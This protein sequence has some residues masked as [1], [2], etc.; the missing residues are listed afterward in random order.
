MA[1]ES[2]TDERELQRLFSVRKTCLQMLNDRKYIIEDQISYEVFKSRFDAPNNVDQDDLTAQINHEV[3]IRE[4]LTLLASRRDNTED[5]IFVF[6]NGE[7]K[8]KSESIKIYRQKMV[9]NGGVARAILVYKG[10]LTPMAKKAIDY[11][12]EGDG[13]IE[14]F[15]ETELIINI[16]EHK[17]V[18]QHILL[19]DEEVDALL[20]RY[21]AKP[22]QLPRIS[23]DD[24]IARYYG[25]EVDQV[26]K[27][28]R[29]SETAGRYV[30]YRR[31]IQAKR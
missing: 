22:S 15:K 23:S 11:A 6:F 16:T 31:V 30:T 5:Q 18:P 20:A 17:W 2:K 9:A 1:D 28:V 10:I 4:K 7:E 21:K 25:L 19:T 24:P 3:P 13:S 8:I 29:R 12:K 27:I 14:Y 26:V